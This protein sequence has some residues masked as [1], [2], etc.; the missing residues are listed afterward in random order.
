MFSVGDVVQVQDMFSLMWING[1][2]TNI[3]K[4]YALV[5]CIRDV[6]NLEHVTWIRKLNSK[7]IK[8]LEKYNGSV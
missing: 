6:N 5:R 4:T 8:L 1:I 7:E 2:I 3:E